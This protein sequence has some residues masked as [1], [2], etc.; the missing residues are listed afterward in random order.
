M[1]KTEPGLL[2]SRYELFLAL[3]Y[4]R[5]RRKQA[6]TSIVT[7]VSILGITV[8]VMAL[9]IALALLTGFQNDI[10]TKIVGANAHVAIWARGLQPMDN[11]DEVVAAAESI[12]GVVSAAPVIGNAGL[13]DTGFGPAFAHVKGVD[14]RGESST[15]ELFNRLIEGSVD[16][17]LIDNSPAGIILGTDMADTLLVRVGDQVRVIVPAP[18]LL[19]PVGSGIKFGDFRVVGIFDAGMHEYDNTWALV[20]LSEAQDLF[21]MGDTV[22]M[23]ELRVEDIY[24]TDPIIEGLRDRLGD[25]YYITDWKQMNRLFFSALRLERLAMFITISLIVLVAALNIVASLVL[26]VMEKNRD[27]GILLSMGATRRAILYTFMSQ[28]LII[29]LVGTAVGLVLGIV[30]SVVMDTYQLISLP[31]Q[32]YY[33]SYVPFDVRPADFTMV[34]L[35]AIAISFLATI[36]PAWR[37]SRLDP[38]EALR[39]E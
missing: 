2:T 6:F 20:S 15:T 28:G 11:Y 23:V 19:T 13:I 34:A 5:A 39:Y 33:L 1:A 27:I 9:V 21:G 29:G 35:L 8:G 4:L 17:L 32:V 36:Y 12:P 26:M 14:P 22:T 24:G 3:R 30:T 10:Q 31:A 25:G 38:V 37:A 16:G 7:V 18:N